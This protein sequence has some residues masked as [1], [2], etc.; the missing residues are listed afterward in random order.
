MSK[1]IINAYNSEGLPVPQY[2]QGFE[3]PEG[4]MLPDVDLRNN[5]E[6]QE[7]YPENHRSE[8]ARLQD[9]KLVLI[10]K[11]LKNT[12]VRPAGIVNNLQY[13]RFMKHARK[14]FLSKDGKLYR[15][16][17]NSMHRLVVDKE[18]RMYMIRASH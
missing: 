17:E 5:P 14:F 2:L 3:A 10:R 12:L 11:W 6:K 7:P 8:T 18:Y 4:G 1:H 9:K 15:R 13:K 16:E